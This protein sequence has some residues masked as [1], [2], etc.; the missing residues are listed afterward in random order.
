M[1]GLSQ[2]T[3]MTLLKIGIVPVMLLSILWRNRREK[4]RRAEA[5]ATLVSSRKQ[6]RHEV[7][8]PTTLDLDD[9]RAALNRLDGGTGLVTPRGEPIPEQR[10][11]KDLADRLMDAGVFDEAELVLTDGPE[12]DAGLILCRAR[13]F[14]HRGRI[15]EA[16][17][18]LSDAADLQLAA[19]RQAARG[20]RVHLAEMLAS[21]M[22]RTDEPKFS[23]PGL[24]RFGPLP[25]LHLAGRGEEAR[26]LAADLGAVLDRALT[27]QIKD[28][29]GRIDG[30]P[31]ATVEK[32]RN[33]LSAV[34]GWMA[35]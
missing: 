3:L 1:Y 32:I 34:P 11:R 27:T 16:R 12:R 24:T 20:M 10:L 29:D 22:P 28:A 23:D 5:E 26:E 15:D 17:T 25:C 21:G 33:T 13:L 14:A 9:L 2:D 8:D 7:I 4:C 6:S 18:A 30:L 35:V 19:M 31:I